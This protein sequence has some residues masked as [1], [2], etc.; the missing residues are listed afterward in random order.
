YDAATARFPGKRIVLWGESLGTGVAV[1]LAVERRVGGVILDA[2]YTS[3]ADV[4][5]AHFPFAPVRWLVKDA[6]HSDQRIAR[7]RAPLLIRHG[8]ADD[9]VPIRFGERL[10]ALANE[11]K[12]F[13]RVPGGGHVVEDDAGGMKSVLAFLAGL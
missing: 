3:I 10:F 5:A 12:K 7:V 11:P 8:E 4:G 13:R 6:F 9:V 1:A 2:P